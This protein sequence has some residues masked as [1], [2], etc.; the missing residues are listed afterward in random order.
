MHFVNVEQADIF[1]KALLDFLSDR[2]A[3]GIDDE[4]E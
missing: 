2:T 3:K 1:N 4:S